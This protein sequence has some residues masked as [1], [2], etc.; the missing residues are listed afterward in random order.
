MLDLDGTEVDIV[1]NTFNASITLSGDYAINSVKLYHI[2]DNSS[3]P[4]IAC[5]YPIR[6]RALWVSYLWSVSLPDH[7]LSLFSVSYTSL[8]VCGFR[9]HHC[10]LLSRLIGFGV[11]PYL[12]SICKTQQSPVFYFCFV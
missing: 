7:M 9:L 3:T 10:V 4:Q 11:V 8:S 6:V 2:S 5:G 12:F 1:I